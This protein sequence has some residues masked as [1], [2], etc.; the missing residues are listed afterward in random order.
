M[1]AF[2]HL[3]DKVFDVRFLEYLILVV[4]F[5]E[6]LVKLESLVEARHTLFCV[7]RLVREVS[8]LEGYLDRVI[9]QLQFVTDFMEA[10]IFLTAQ[11]WSQ[12]YCHLDVGQTVLYFLLQ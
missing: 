5:R 9:A 7:V 6:D 11:D 12:P 1:E 2:Y 8:T 10:K 3:L 4:H